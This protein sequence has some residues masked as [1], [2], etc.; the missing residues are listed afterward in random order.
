MHIVMKTICVH[1]SVF[2]GLCFAA[3]ASAAMVALAAWRL[4]GRGC[5]SYRDEW[6]SA[7]GPLSNP[8]NDESLLSLTPKLESLGPGAKTGGGGTEGL[9]WWRLVICYCVAFR[10]R[11][12]YPP[13]PSAQG[14]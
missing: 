5:V 14:L 6:P 7:L 9:W 4:S 11:T 1:V 3:A 12:S 13:P 8:A 2:P 10:G